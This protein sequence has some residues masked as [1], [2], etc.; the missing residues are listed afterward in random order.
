MDNICEN[1]FCIADKIE[2]T[3][4]KSII[5]DKEIPIKIGKILSKTFPTPEEIK[6]S[7]SI[8]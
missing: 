8:D 5:E 2:Q 4:V 7:I 1:N 6:A 3:F